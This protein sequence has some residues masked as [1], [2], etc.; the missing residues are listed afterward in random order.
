MEKKLVV[1]GHGTDGM[2]EEDK[3]QIKKEREL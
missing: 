3:E 2:K 1:G